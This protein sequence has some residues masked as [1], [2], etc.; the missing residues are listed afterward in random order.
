VLIVLLLLLLLL[1]NVLKF[2]H[3]VLF[4]HEV[5]NAINRLRSTKSVR[6]EG[7]TNFVIKGC[8]EILVRVLKFICNPALF[9]NTF[10]NLW[11]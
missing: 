9:Q 6:L 10:P 4:K 7:I 2:Y 8:S 11:K 1:Y 5:Q 3:Y